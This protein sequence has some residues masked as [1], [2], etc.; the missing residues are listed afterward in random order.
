MQYDFYWENLSETI[1][2]LVDIVQDDVEINLYLHS[3]QNRKE[4]E[5]HYICL[6]HV[7]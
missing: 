7:Q 1:I 3:L 5:R 6:Y 4:E 2:Y